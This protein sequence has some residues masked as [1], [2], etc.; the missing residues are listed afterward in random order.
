MISESGRCTKVFI[1]KP[2]KLPRISI[3]FKNPDDPRLL[4]SCTEYPDSNRKISPV[5]QKIM[6]ADPLYRRMCQKRTPEQKDLDEATKLRTTIYCI[7]SYLY[8]LNRF[9]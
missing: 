6:A 8:I 5:V 4:L 3:T 7:L 9:I 1:R 2:Y